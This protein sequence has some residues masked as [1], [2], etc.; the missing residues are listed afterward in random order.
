MV[1]AFNFKDGKLLYCNRWTKTH[2]QQKELKTGS[3][4]GMNLGD[5]V[6]VGV[7]NAPLMML[8][9]DVGYTSSFPKHEQTTANTALTVHQNRT[10]AL[11]E[12][13]FPF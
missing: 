2:K 5:L 7:F 4:V 12:V 13:D 9:G 3:K 11:L 10:F 6:G 8:M 1:H